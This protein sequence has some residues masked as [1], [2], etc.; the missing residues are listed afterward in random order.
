MS[1]RVELKVDGMTCPACARSVTRKLSGVVGVSN[2]DVDFATGKAT[3]EYDTSS[4]KIEDLIAAMI[5]AIEQIG[6]RAQSN[7]GN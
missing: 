7:H 2:A 1:A 3:V 5:S 4:G 6:Y